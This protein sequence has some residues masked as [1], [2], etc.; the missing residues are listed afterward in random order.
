MQST[1]KFF[2][3]FLTFS[4]FLVGQSGLL[5]SLAQLAVAYTILAFTLTSVCAISTNGAVEGGGCYCILFSCW[6]DS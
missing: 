2:F 3:F 1:Y 4:G 5:E 6:K